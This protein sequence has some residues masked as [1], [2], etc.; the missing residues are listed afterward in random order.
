MAELLAA[1]V[2]FPAVVPTV[3]FGVAVL[4]WLLVMFGA[5]DIDLFSADGAADGVLDGAADG[6]AHGLLHGAADGAADGVLDGVADGAVDGAAHGL[7][8]GAADGAADGVLDGVADG[9]ADGVVDGAVDGAA[10]A[11]SHA[12][13]HAP[14][15][16]AME[17]AVEAS[18]GSN[19]A[20][21]VSLAHFRSVPIT[22]VASVLVVFAWLICVVAVRALPLALTGVTSW[23]VGAAVLL[24][25]FLLAL[26]PT[27][28]VIRPLGRFFQ[29]HD[30]KSHRDFIGRICVVST[31]SVSAKYG[32]ARLHQN[33]LDLIL[34]VRTDSGSALKKG[35]RALILSWDPKR[36]AFLVDPYDKLLGEGD[37]A[38]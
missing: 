13:V 33:D 27:A 17:G 25:A 30:A 26:P 2:A 11:A 35:D 31:G 3:L 23:L 16:H 8:H 15:G 28:I 38:S 29:V 22:V 12:L 14:H 32:Q 20:S 7:L 37:K 1:I 5:L 10:D 36:E 19:V 24:G 9:A 4:Y 21:M 34:Q 18:G 6:A